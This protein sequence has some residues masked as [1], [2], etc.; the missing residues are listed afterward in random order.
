MQ[1]HNPHMYLNIL[2]EGLQMADK[3]RDR[4]DGSIFFRKSDSR[5]VGKYIPSSNAKPIV[6]YGKTEAGVKKK[7][8]ELK[9]EVHKGDYA[10]VQRTSVQD[11][12]NNWFY[13]I[14]VNELK[15]RTFDS[16]ENVLNQHV[17]PYIGDIQMG[18]LI[19]N[20]VQLMVNKLAEK[21]LA[22]DT[23]KKAYGYVNACSKLGII[24][25]D[26]G[27]N[28]CIGVSLPKILK[29]KKGDIR[30]FTMEEAQ[31]IC[32]ECVRTYQN[33][34]PVYRLGHSI[35]VLIYTGLR[36]GELLGLKWKDI[37]FENKTARIVDSVVLVQD[38]SRANDNS[39]KYILLE[40]ESV[41]TEAGER[42]IQL[43]QK[44][45]AALKAIYNIN[46]NHTH[47]MA[48]TSGTINCPNNVRRMLWRILSRCEIEQC[49]LHSLRHTFASML[50]KAGVDVKTVSE[51]LGHAD[52]RVTYDTYIHL[53]K[54]QKQQA[55]D[56]L[57]TL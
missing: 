18:S 8:R 48:T 57:D 49:G 2:W 34:I 17:Y 37:N 12:M 14:K 47:V 54:E 31:L 24:K 36:I 55:V 11:Y 40:Q 29:R 50:F 4:G 35:I 38:R 3:R 5:W 23:I 19:I 33:G 1:A 41:K 44:A 13:T 52:V 25:G 27:K 7:L 39:P 43:N 6:I 32:N 51:L 15:P 10:V 56:I 26:I 30:F 45:I 21:K 53:I 42:K 22:F 9:K 46:G 16:M 20:D 28:P